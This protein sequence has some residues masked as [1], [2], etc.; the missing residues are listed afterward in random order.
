MRTRVGIVEDEILIADSIAAALEDLGYEALEPAMSYT[1]ALEMISRDKPDIL[2]LDIQ[3]NGKK[4]G[5]EL[6]QKVK[7]DFG[8]PFIFLTASSDALTIERVK[9]LNPPAYIVKPFTREALFASIEICLHNTSIKTATNGPIV[10]KDN[11]I[12]KDSVFIKSGQYFH[13]IKID[14]ILYLESDK[15]Y[16]YVHT[17]N[18]K[19]WVRSSFQEFIDLVAGRQFVRIQKGYVVN[20]EKI[21]TINTDKIFVGNVELPIGKSYRD[22]LLQKLMIA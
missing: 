12:I 2:L 5:V 4:D 7:D 10:P 22:D 6:A 16:I 21:T 19:L 15:N 1:E 20:A 18:D 17:T 14:D 3:L 11:Y 8:I 13:R 9:H